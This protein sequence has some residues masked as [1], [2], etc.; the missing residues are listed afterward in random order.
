L[1]YVKQ[2]FPREWFWRMTQFTYFK[3]LYRENIFGQKSTYFHACFVFNIS[4]VVYEDLPV[5]S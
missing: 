2:I 3:I 4:M 1:E 5:K